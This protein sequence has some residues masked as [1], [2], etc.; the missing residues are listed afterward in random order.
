MLIRDPQGA[1][2]S[3]ALLCTDL[4]AT[5]LQIVQWFVLRWRVEVTF[6]EARAH[7]GVETQRQWSDMAIARTTPALLG[8]FSLVTLLAHQVGKS[9]PL[10]V[11]EAA[12]SD[13]LAVVRYELWHHRDFHLSLSD[14]DV[15]EIPR[16]LLMRFIDTLCYA[17]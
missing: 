3:R 17:A 7:L 8:L 5:P 11:R 9:E 15:V 6:Q 12:F 1:F 16:S 10:P 14:P 4:S 13:A 2:E